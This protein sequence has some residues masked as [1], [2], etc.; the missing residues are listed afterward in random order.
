MQTSN[1]EVKDFA[2]NYVLLGRYY[3]RY[4]D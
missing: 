3:F 2:L 4:Q 1:N